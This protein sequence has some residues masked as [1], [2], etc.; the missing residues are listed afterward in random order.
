MKKSF[1]IVLCVVLS[2]VA[3][4]TIYSCDDSVK[5]TEYEN[6]EEYNIGNKTCYEQVDK[7][8]VD[9]N[10]GSI[11]L[12]NGNNDSVSVVENNTELTLE[13]KVH[14]YFSN[15]IFYVKFW[16]SGYSSIIEE[17]D[18][19]LILSVPNDMELVINASNSKVNVDNELSVKKLE[20]N[21]DNSDIVFESVTAD[22]LKIEN[23]SGQIQIKKLYVSE[24]NIDAGKSNVIVNFKRNVYSKIK[25]TTGDVELSTSIFGAQITFQTSRGKLITLK[26]YEYATGIYFFGTGMFEIDVVTTKGDLVVK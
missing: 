3:I 20:I 13:Q 6:A 21:A 5:F 10:V 4:F 1:I 11:Y 12:K 26:E 17:D 22:E 7:V 9:W 16:Q 23:T 8:I 2:V 15:G 24:L 25:T 19:V 14:T 18:K